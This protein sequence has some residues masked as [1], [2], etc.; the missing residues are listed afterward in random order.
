MNNT[1]IPKTD[2]IKELAHFWD[3][4]DLTDYEDQLEEVEDTVFERKTNIRIDLQIS[5]AE[6]IKKIAKKRGIPYPAL[7]RE[8]VLDKIKAA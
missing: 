4:H 6:A 3:T 8:W 5:E 2:S 1:T 7:V